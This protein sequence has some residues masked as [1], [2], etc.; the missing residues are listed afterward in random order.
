MSKQIE[1]P[2]IERRN[3]STKL[4]RMD[5]DD[6]ESRKIAG[7]A[8]VY[9]NEYKL[10]GRYYERVAPGALTEALKDS[11]CRALFNHD[12]NL[13]LAREASG[14]LTLT[15]SDDGLAYEFD[16]PDTTTGNDLLALIERGDIRESSFAFMV[17]E[18]D[19]SYEYDE[20]G[21]MTKS[22]RTITRISALYDVSPVTYPANP[23][24]SVA[25][26]G[27]QANPGEHE[28]RA[29]I[30]HENELLDIDIRMRTINQ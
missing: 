27:F 10:W 19:Y 11:D 1:T 9:D 23:D 20:D 7:T 21:Y 26:R 24:T 25:K 13:L 18:A 14:T 17:A 4:T 28:R 3:F 12:Q 8:T 15:D 29:R 22:L 6:T 16:A 5:G 30:E 2:Q